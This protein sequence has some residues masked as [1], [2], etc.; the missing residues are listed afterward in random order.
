MPPIMPK[1][2]LISIQLPYL[3][4]SIHLHITTFFVWMLSYLEDSYEYSSL[5]KEHFNRNLCISVK[6]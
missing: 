4:H 2:S 3:F 1:F 6:N 5:E